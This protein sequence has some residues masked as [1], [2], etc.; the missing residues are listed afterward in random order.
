M[1]KHD[2]VQTARNNSEGR[3]PYDVLLYFDSCSQSLPSQRMTLDSANG[4]Q[5][6][7]TW[8][9]HTYYEQGFNFYIEYSRGQRRSKWGSWT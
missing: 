9:L 4:D 5:S 6:A 2:V 8:S 1:V 3:A 7:N